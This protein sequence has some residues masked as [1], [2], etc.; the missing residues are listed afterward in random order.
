MSTITI[1]KVETRKDLKRFIEFHY[2][3]Y[4]GNEYDAPVLYSDD[5][6]TLSKDKNAAFEFCESEYYLA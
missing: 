6:A 5:L 2:E 1:K 4:K 3:L